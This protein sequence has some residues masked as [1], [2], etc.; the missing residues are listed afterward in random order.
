[1]KYNEDLEM[2]SST[3]INAPV[4]KVWSIISDIDDDIKFWKAI[5]SIRNLSIEKNVVKR[6]VVLGKVNKCLQTVTLFPK[7]KIL[8]EWTKGSILGTKEITLLSQGNTT[9]LDVTMDYKFSGIAG[10]MSGKIKK[11][12]QNES[13]RAVEMIKEIAEGTEKSLNMEERK[14]WADL[15]NNKS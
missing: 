1:M 14:T 4:E 9:Q 5:T 15:I 2:K 13:D 3:M 11:D 8:T 7:E 12:I 6:E 10:F